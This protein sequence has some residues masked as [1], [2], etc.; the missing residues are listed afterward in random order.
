M[1]TSIKTKLA[2]V[3]LLSTLFLVTMMGC[4]NKNND[5]SLKQENNKDV[6]MHVWEAFNHGNIEV[7]DEVI[8]ES[9]IELTPYSTIQQGGPE[10]VKDAY[11]WMKSV[12]GNIQFE[13]EQMIAEGDYVFSRA[14]ATGT[15]EEEFMGVP[16]TGRP[17]RF[18]AVVVSKISN[19][20]LIQDWSFVDAMKILQQLGKV[21]VVPFESD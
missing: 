15:H 13:V 10:R 11:K 12:F 14:M 16:A 18:A 4:S 9:Y 5:L 17:I 1:E 2:V 20:K 6:V 7:L 8:D 3:K 21:S 19:G